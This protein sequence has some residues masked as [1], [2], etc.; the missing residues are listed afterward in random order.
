MGNKMN[1]QLL[2]HDTTC[3]LCGNEDTALLFRLNDTPLEDQFVSGEQSAVEQPTYPLE[4]ALCEAC[5]YVFLPYIVSPEV[6]YADYVYVSGVTVGLRNHYDEYAEKIISEYGLPKESLVVD[7]GSNDGSMLASFKR[8]GMRVTG[9][10]PARAIA[11]HATA[12]GLP[13]INNFFT[14]E[15]ATQILTE[16]GPASVITANYMYA[17]VDDVINFTK[18]VARLLAADGVFVVQTGYHPEQMKVNMF[19]YIYHEHFSY[20]TVEVLKNTFAACGLELVYAEKTVPK[21]GSIRV[22]GQRQEGTR[23]IDASVE[24]VIREEQAGAMK[25]VDTYLSFSREINDAKQRVL[26]LLAGLKKDGKKIIGLG[27]SHSTTTL[28]YHF[29][30]EPYLEYLVDDN[31]LKH[32]MFSPG[33]HLPVKPT[34]ELGRDMPDYVVVLAWQHQHSIL[35]R[36]KSFLDTGGKF[37]IPLPSLTI[38]DANNYDKL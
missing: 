28:T 5:G 27:A 21:G 20:F 23:P 14:D 35:Q 3:R 2:R 31:E 11:E 30:L 29:E 7:L 25:H 6:S 1:N 19:D 36:H 16:N 32:N 24:S 37:I 13:T 9:V 10:E 15:V 33:Y 18:T 34:T 22:V 26:A 12:N 8:L 38:V 4:L 17:N